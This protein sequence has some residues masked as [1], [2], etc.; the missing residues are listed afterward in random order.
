[1]SPGIDHDLV[2]PQL[3]GKRPQ[4]RADLLRS[5]DH[6]AGAH[7][8]DYRQ[9]VGSEAARFD[10]IGRLQRPEDT[11]GAIDAPTFT[12]ER[13]AHGSLVRLR[14]KRPNADGRLRLGMTLAGAVKLAIKVQ[15]FLCALPV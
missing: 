5:A 9:L 3:L 4:L 11:A 6:C 12:S 13:M 8:F 10:F 15:R 7:C 2:E 14:G 1:M